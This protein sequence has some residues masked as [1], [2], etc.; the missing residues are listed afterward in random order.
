MKTHEQRV[1][2][3]LESIEA[4]GEK[5]NNKRK[6]LLTLL[7]WKVFDGINIPDELMRN[8]LSQGTNPETITR[9]LRKVQE[10]QR[11]INSQHKG[12]RV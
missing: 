11:I 8:I 6:I 4:L 7:Y 9:V 12:G 2:Y 3:L 5:D 1:T 10:Q